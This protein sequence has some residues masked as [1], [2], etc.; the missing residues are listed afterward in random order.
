VDPQLQTLGAQLA[1][2]MVRNSAFAIGDKIRGAR[3]RRQDQETIAELETM[4]NDLVADKSEL[5]RIANAYEDE[6]VAQRLAKEDIEYISKNLVPLLGELVASSA[7]SE[8]AQAFQEVVQKLLSVETV[9]VLQLVGFNF[10]KAIGEPLT[11]LV[12]G[13][14]ATRT[15]AN[16]SDKADVVLRTGKRHR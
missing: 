6:L 3:A 11:E 9:T 16:A 2:V 5:V 1:E 10:R 7:E 13:F 8:Q 14:I 12:A 4:V 15:P